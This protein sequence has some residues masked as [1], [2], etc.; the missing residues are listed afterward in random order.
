MKAL[1][2]R[3]ED[4]LHA[5]A[6]TKAEEVGMSLAEVVRA[7]VQTFCTPGLAES[8]ELVNEWRAQL[9]TKDTQLDKLLTELAETRRA[10]EDA[11]KRHDT[12]V[13]HLT[14]QLEHA[15][16]QLEDL[17]QKSTWWRRVLKRK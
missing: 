10:V 2:V 11:S 9:H 6:V 1:S 4:G 13:L 14:Q 8:K 5:L 16:L 15:H 12:I 7:A 3:V 17:R